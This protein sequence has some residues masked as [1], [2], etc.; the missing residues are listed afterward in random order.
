MDLAAARPGGS[1]GQD[2]SPA[3]DLS[4]PGAPAAS[5]GDYGLDLTGEFQRPEV[6]EL[7]VQAR[8]DER[9]RRRTSARMRLTLARTVTGTWSYGLEVWWRKR[10]YREA[11]VALGARH[12][13][14]PE[15]AVEGWLA[16]VDLL[17]DW[18][19]PETTRLEVIQAA[20]RWRPNG[21]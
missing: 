6:V 18:R 8:L 11:C 21:I 16:A 1:T 4:L 10:H 17:R 7:W 20:K 5:P 3:P 14:R 13:S 15:A 9:G 19:A 2:L 12:R